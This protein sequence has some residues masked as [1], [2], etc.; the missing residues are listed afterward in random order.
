MLEF[1]VNHTGALPVYALSA[2]ETPG[3]KLRRLRRLRGLTLKQVAGAIEVSEQ[4]VSAI[5]LGKTKGAKPENFLKLCAFYEIEDPWR[6]VFEKS[7]S[8]V[9][10]DLRTRLSRRSGT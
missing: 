2:M 7:R 10:S 6:F 5:E 4:A 9:A 1:R 3:A 8:E